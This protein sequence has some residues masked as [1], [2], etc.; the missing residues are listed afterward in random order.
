MKSRIVQLEERRRA[1]LA[2]IEAQRHSLAWQLE[3]FQ[4]TSGGI[5]WARRRGS[6][7]AATPPLAWL[8]GIAGLLLLLRPLRKSIRWLPWL[9]GA[10]S[11]ITR[12]REVVRLV[13][14]LRGTRAPVKPPESR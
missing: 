10:L 3:H 11:L 4:L 1:L 9:A 14:E 8:A 6:A 13:N 7:S 2:Q 12:G 5:S